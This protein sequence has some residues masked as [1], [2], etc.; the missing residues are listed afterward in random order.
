MVQCGWCSLTPSQ[1]NYA[2]VELELAAVWWAADKCD[3]YLRGMP[4]FKVLTDYWPLVGLFGKAL[5][6]L[7][8][9]RLQRLRE[10]LAM[11]MFKVMLVPGKTH[12]IAD[13]LSHAPVFPA[14]PDLDIVMCAA[15]STF[16]P[17]SSWRPSMT[18]TACSG[19]VSRPVAGCPQDFFAEMR[20]E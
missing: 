15:V 12:L 20:V 14:V 16:D 9:V 3:Y 11:Y 6:L 10:N 8:N 5:C 18:S 17:P 2:V 19:T 4:L 13:A 1:K 7:G